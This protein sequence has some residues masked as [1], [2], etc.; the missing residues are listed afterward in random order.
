MAQGPDADVSNAFKR[1]FNEP[2]DDEIKNILEGKD[3]ENTKKAT[4]GALKALHE[5][6]DAKQLPQ[7]IDLSEQELTNVLF[8]FYAAVKQI[9]KTDEPYSVQTLK[10]MRAGL[11]RYFCTEK[12][13]DII[14]GKCFVQA[15]EIFKGMCVV[16]KKSGKGVKRSYPSITDIDMEQISEYFNYDHMHQPDPQ[17]LQKHLLFYIIYFFCCRGKENLYA[18]TQDT[19]ALITEPTGVQYVIQKIDEIDK[20]HSYEDTNQTNE[21]RMY[22]NKGTNSLIKHKKAKEIHKFSQ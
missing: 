13:W 20:N 4:E 8:K 15:N 22:G 18:M 14:K 5:Y 12:G 17:R 7:V 11:S 9:K 16:S 19:F 1:T 6:L 3:K 10:C 21:G 2:S